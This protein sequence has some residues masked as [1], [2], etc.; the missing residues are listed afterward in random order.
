MTRKMG[1]DLDKSHGAN[2]DYSSVRTYAT[3]EISEIIDNCLDIINQN[4]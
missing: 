2:L 1:P 4:A 3:K